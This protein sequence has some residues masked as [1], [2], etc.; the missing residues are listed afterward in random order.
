MT[1][2]GQRHFLKVRIVTERKN[3]QEIKV[4]NGQRGAENGWGR[5]ISDGYNKWATEKIDWSCH[6]RRLTLENRH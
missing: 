4:T 3:E 1:S 5:K 6:E 2:T